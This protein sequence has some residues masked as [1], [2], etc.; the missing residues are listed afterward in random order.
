MVNK[1]RIGRPRGSSSRLLNEEPL[2]GGQFQDP[3]P[4]RLSKVVLSLLLSSITEP[5]VI[6]ENNDAARTNSIEKNL[7]GRNFGL[8]GI[9]VEMQECNPIGHHLRETIWHQSA[10]D[11]R[12]GKSGE[13]LSN[14]FRITPPLEKEGSYVFQYHTHSEYQKRCHKGKRL[15]L[16]GRNQD[17]P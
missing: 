5:A 11:L 2:A 7:E 17:S 4:P 14:R 12:I 3:I 16:C 9:H 8:G 15:S 13:P 6:V 1:T 10:N